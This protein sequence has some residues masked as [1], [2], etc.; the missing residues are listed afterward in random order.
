[1]SEDVTV[2]PTRYE[3]T[4]YPFHDI[5]RSDWVIT[6]ERRAEDAWAVLRRSSCWNRRTKQWDHEPLPSSRTDAFKRTH[7]FPLEQ[8]LTIACEQAP[9]LTMMGWTVESA[10]EQARQWQTEDAR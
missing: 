4:A 9:K 10:T 7:R 1:M 5:N 2:E 3:V 6:V 8:A